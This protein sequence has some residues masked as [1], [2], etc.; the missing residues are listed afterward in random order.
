MEKGYLSTSTRMIALEAGIT[1][2]NL[3]HYFKNKEEIYI[4]VLDDLATVVNKDLLKIVSEHDDSIENKLKEIFLYLKE[5]H[6]VNLNIMQHDISHEISKK[7]QYRLYQIWRKAYL[8]PLI[9]LFDTQ[10]ADHLSFSSEELARHFFSTISPYIQR[11]ER[12]YEGLSSDQIIH[13]FVYGIF[14]NNQ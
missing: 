13:L 1:Q 14:D 10:A 6:P 5:K 11:Y 7:N 9:T 8:S 12:T 3:Y 2:P 4:A